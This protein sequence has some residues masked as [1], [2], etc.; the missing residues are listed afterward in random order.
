MALAP[1]S[2]DDSPPESFDTRID[3]VC[4]EFESAWRAGREPLIE[5]YLEALPPSQRGKLLE[6]LLVVDLWHR[7][8]RGQPVDAPGYRLRF[9]GYEREVDAAWR[10]ESQRIT[11]PAAEQLTS[12]GDPAPQARTGSANSTSSSLLGQVQRQDPEGWRRL[13]DVYGPSIYGWCRRA[14]LQSADAADVAQ[15]VFSS[16]VA[17]ISEFHPVR[18]GSFRTWLRRITEHRLAD[19]F[20]AQ[21]TSPQALGG[22]DWAAE[23]QVAPNPDSGSGSSELEGAVWQRVLHV[24]RAEF[25]ERSWQS[26]WQV[27]VDSQRPVDVAAELGMTVQAVYQAKSRILGRIRRAFAEL[28]DE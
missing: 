8:L 20:R 2:Q 11:P 12:A 7:R 17:S 14:G 24:V 28:E 22:S 16:V 6:E 19:H 18:R 23:L 25:E 5:P 15:E 1:N 4:D 13:V 9:P 26:F 3:Q 10:R 21:R 27:V